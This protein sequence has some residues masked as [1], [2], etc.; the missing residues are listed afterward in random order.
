MGLVEPG[1]MPRPDGHKPRGKQR[2]T[3]ADGHGSIAI[4]E[5]GRRSASRRHPSP[6]ASRRDRK[7]EMQGNLTDRVQ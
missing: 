6:G 4:F 1:L 7:R 3:R 2:R 5:R